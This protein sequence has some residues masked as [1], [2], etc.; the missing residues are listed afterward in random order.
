M[1]ESKK[2]E[3]AK[4][5]LTKMEEA[6]DDHSSFVYNLSAFLSAS[7]SVLQYALNESGKTVNGNRWYQSFVI[8][9]SILKFFKN[10]RD[11]NIHEKPVSPPSNVQINISDSAHIS[12][13]ISVVIRDKDGNIL[14]QFTSSPQS[15]SHDNK[16]NVTKRVSYQFS[17]WNGNNDVLSLC[18]D[19]LKQLET[20]IDEG[21]CKGFIA[22]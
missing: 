7:R 12:E 11:V 8:S 16:P 2:L 9:S 20:L 5:F 21:I 22:G 18:R 1:N 3:E 14:N 6:Q 19:Y 15:T 17:E 10:K 13:S 4:Y